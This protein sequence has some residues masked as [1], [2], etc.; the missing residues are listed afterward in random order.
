[1]SQNEQI[2]PAAGGLTP[3]V[4][5][6]A[7]EPVVALAKPNQSAGTVPVGFGTAQG[8]E[9]LQRIGKMF[10]L[11]NLVPTIYQNNLPNCVIAVEMAA[12]IGASPLMVMQNL[13]IVSGKPGWS[14]KFLVA[15]F[16]TT[17]K[18]SPI[19]YRKYGTEGQ[20]DWGRSAY[21]KD[22]MT[23]EVVEGPKVTI[24]MAKKEGWYAKNGSKWQTIPELMLCY[25]SAS[26]MVNT[27]SPEITMGI[28]TVE[29]LEDIGPGPQLASAR[30]IE[31]QV[32]HSKEEE[33]SARLGISEPAPV[34]PTVPVE[35]APQA[36]PY[37]VDPSAPPAPPA[38]AAPGRQRKL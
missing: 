35:A 8:F 16:N 28:H 30:V 34:A 36:D 19:K 24:E 27:T 25:R 2:Q 1:M 32:I 15:A 9:A 21:A 11:S 17:G 12:R 7:Q 29:E 18:F 26:F 33:I 10:A 6:P 4:I 38:P 3:A 14:A 31:G 5:D 23:G 37:P 22:L 20:D 13:Y